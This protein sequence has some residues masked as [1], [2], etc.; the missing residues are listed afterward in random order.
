MKR[1]TVLISGTGSNLSAL[2][3]ACAAPGFAASIT[4]VIANRGDAK[5]IELARA[6]GIN[7]VIIDHQKFTGRA[8]HEAAIVAE[9]ESDP[10]DLICLAGYMRVL[11]AAF[12]ANFHG[13]LLNIHPSL[14]PSFPGLDTHQRA[15]DAGVKVHG[16]TV[17]FVSAKVDAGPIIAQGAVPVLA[18]DDAATLAKRVLTLEH[19]LYPLALAMVAGD[20]AWLENDRVVYQAKTGKTAIFHAPQQ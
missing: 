17:H 1:V 6:A 13:R 14:L 2:L 20:K 5:G 9:L 4:K 12:V 16:C 15:L 8:A 11:S 10:P 3:V 19:K 18:G 7:P